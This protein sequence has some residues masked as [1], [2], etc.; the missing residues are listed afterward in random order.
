MV[1][2]QDHFVEDAIRD[3]LPGGNP[4]TTRRFLVIHFTGGWSAKSAVEYWRTPAAQGAN[5]HVVIDRDGSIRQCRP[6][7]RTCG[8][9]GRNSFW[10]DPNSSFTARN[11]GVNACSIGIELANCGDLERTSYPSTMGA[12]WANKTIPRTRL[13]HKNGGP[14]KA[15]EVYDQRQLDACF[16]LAVELFQRYHLDDCVGHDDVAPQWKNDPG[17]AFPM[18]GLRRTLGLPPLP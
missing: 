11:A 9:A 6:F 13:R 5:A 7:N 4:M 10:K 1:I 14:L 12:E 15:W 8:H 17:P 2:T 16:Q 3:L 18:V